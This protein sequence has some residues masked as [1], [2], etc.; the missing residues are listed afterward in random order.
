MAAQRQPYSR[1]F[2]SWVR[3]PF[4]LSTGLLMK[5]KCSR[6]DLFGASHQLFHFFVVAAA[7]AHYACIMRAFDHWH[8]EGIKC[9]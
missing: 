4:N 3:F 7:V 2:L 5:P 1:T 9:V 6:F 8:G